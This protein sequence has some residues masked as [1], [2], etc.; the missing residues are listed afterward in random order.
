M[1]LIDPHQSWLALEKRAATEQ[2]PRLCQLLNKVRDHMEFEIKGDLEPLM[3][4]LIDEPVYHFWNENPFVLRG[5]DQV[6][7]FYQN[8]IAS[9]RNQFEIVV[10]RIVVDQDAVV[11]EG[12]VRQVYGGEVA[13]AM[14]A[15][16]VGGKPIQSD[17]LILTSTQLITVWPA[18]A[19][20]NLVG[21]DIYFG[22]SPFQDAR[23]ISTEDLPE[24]YKG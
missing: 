19:D 9:G 8:M 16:E 6:R 3:N 18:A 15:T 1:S 11:T 23:R 17:D 12:Q 24:Y 2:D 14:G 10:E 21:E 22:T 4:T 13:Q 7:D 5:S 20:G